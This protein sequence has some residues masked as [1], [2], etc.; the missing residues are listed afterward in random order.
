MKYCYRFNVLELSVRK[1]F[2]DLCW[3]GNGRRGHIMVRC[4]KLLLNFTILLSV[5]Q[6]VHGEVIPYEEGLQNE[7][8]P[9]TIRVTRLNCINM[10]YEETVVNECRTILRLW[11]V[12]FDEV[13]GNYE[14]WRNDTRP[15]TIRFT[16]ALCVGLPYPETVV[17]EC[18]VTLRRNERTLI[19]VTIHLPK[20]Y[21]FMIFQFRLHYKFTTYRPLLL[22]GE[23]EVCSL[24]R[25]TKLTPMDDYAYVVLK[26][27][28][29]TAAHPCPHGVTTN[30]DE[31]EN[32]TRPFSLRVVKLLCINQPYEETVVNECRVILRRNERSLI[33]ASV[34]APKVYVYI[35]I[36]Y[37]LYY[38]FTTYKPLLVD[39]ELEL[40][41]YMRGPKTSPLE[42]YAL[43]VMK[44]LLPNTIYPCPHGNK[45]Y[46]ERTEF[47]EEYAPK[48]V[49]AGDYRLDVRF[50]NRLNVTLFW[51]QAFGTVRRR[52]VL[53]S[54]VCRITLGDVVALEEGLQNDTRPFTIR[55]TRLNCINMPYE[56][57]VVKE[58]RII[59]RRNER[60]LL[61]VSVYVPKVYNYVLIQYKLYYKFTTYK[62]LLID[63]HA[64]VCS[65]MRGPRVNPLKNYILAVMKELLPNTVHPCPH[66][67]KTYSERTEF[68][69]EYAPKSIP[70]G[71]Y[72]LDLR[73]SNQLNVTLLW[74]QGFGTV[75]RKG[76]LGSMLEW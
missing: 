57:T 49:P 62:P 21:N 67:N 59:L 30:E 34:T 10:P 75:R 7:T 71:D 42:N 53:G 5:C 56:E 26:D 13:S 35:L 15:V 68:K 54:I 4:P 14:E 43:R 44:E 46:S 16:R 69:E 41:S 24:M 27:L 51:I 58:C 39:G 38:K 1:E 76:I 29:P 11:Y 61:C 64:E 23:I 31:Q 9:F 22:D 55:V 28:L 40:C 60:S 52:G 47:K 6:A 74:I 2:L 70:A 36:Q 65:Y 72:R 45:T 32:K 66:G 33:V 12:F 48:S 37:K 18:G 50:A 8:R 19:Y 3:S 63:G 73:F 25:G 20:V 17:K